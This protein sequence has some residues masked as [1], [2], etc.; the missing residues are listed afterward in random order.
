MVYEFLKLFVGLATARVELSHFNNRFKTLLSR[1]HFILIFG[2]LVTPGVTKAEYATRRK[3][4]IDS[5]PEGTAV[6]LPS[7]SHKLMSND[8]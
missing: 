6:I 1:S 7:A 4:F 3:M 2:L 8:I 5:L